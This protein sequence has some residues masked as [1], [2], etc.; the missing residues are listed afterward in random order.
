MLH[1]NCK[2]PLVSNYHQYIHYAQYDLYRDLRVKNCDF[3][4]TLNP[5]I[6]LQNRCGSAHLSEFN[7]DILNVSKST[8]R[9]LRKIDKL[10]TLMVA[11]FIY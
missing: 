4:K 7:L 2:K 10:I 5:F 1:L 11:R 9:A 6:K 8:Y 3:L